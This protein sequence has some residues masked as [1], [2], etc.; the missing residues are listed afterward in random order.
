MAPKR[1]RLAGEAAAWANYAEFRDQMFPSQTGAARRF[2][3]VT[4]EAIKRAGIRFHPKR[5]RLAVLTQCGLIPGE[6][7]Q[8]RV[9]IPNGSG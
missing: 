3:P 9:S 2:D 1:E 7:S 6:Q 8:P 4:L 5:E